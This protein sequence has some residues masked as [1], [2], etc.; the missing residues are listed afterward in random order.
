MD[1]TELAVER[2]RALKAL[3]VGLALDDFGT[4]YS[5]LSY[6][7]RFPVD[8]LKI[9]RSF[10]ATARP[11][12]DGWPRRV[13]GLGATLALEVVAEGIEVTE[14]WDAL[15]ELGCDLGQGF[16]FARPMD[17]DASIAFLAARA[18]CT[19]ATKAS[20]VPVGSPRSG[21]LTPLRRRDFRRCGSACASR[22]WATARSSSRSRGRS[23]RSQH[24][25]RDGRRRP[26]DDG[27]DDH[28]P[29]DRR[30]GQRPLRAPP[31]MLMADLIRLL[32][33]GA[34]AVLSLT[35]AVALWH[36]IVLV[37]F[38]GAGQAFYAPAFDAITPE[39]LPAEELAQANALDQVVRPIALRMAGPALGG[40]LI[41]A[42]GAGAAFA[43]DAASFA[44]SACALLT[45]ARRAAPV[46]ETPPSH[47]R[48]PERGR[49]LPA[50]AAVAVG[51]VRQ[52]R[53][54]LSAVHGA[55]RGAGPVHRQG[56]ARRQS[57]RAWA[58]VRR[59]RAGVRGGRGL[60]W[61]ARAARAAA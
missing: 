34:L 53:D 14:Q 6:L 7:S 58:R 28:L 20:T 4:G 2:L 42:L 17:A 18:P 49:T 21:L 10:V 11:T 3:G 44:V 51:H 31:L 52:R 37:V 15:R 59:R 36:V 27:A 40:V 46:R 48:R 22:C 43:L 29:A 5:S 61:P 32:A 25:D 1:D 47:D 9:D 24:A 45:L 56:G 16:L 41:G 30:R 26:G 19:I 12:P 54:R 8:I 13:V 57:R 33:V 50:R 55:G 35:G 39:L 23:T 38:Y 60:V